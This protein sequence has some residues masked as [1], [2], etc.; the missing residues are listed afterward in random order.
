MMWI[1]GPTAYQSLWL[2]EHGSVSDSLLL[3]LWDL[4]GC[5]EKH[6]SQGASLW[7]HLG[8]VG[9]CDYNMKGTV[10]LISL[11]HEDSQGWGNNVYWV[12]AG[13]L[14]NRS[15]YVLPW[16]L[17]SGGGED[18]PTYLSSIHIYLPWA[19]TSIK[20]NTASKSGDEFY[21]SIFICTLKFRFYYYL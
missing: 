19:G 14:I 18:K 10:P 13:G 6:M 1:S 12:T 8:T 20:L 2:W 3:A 15:S 4:Q 7:V 21:S 16:S 5:W 9:I 17:H 11:S